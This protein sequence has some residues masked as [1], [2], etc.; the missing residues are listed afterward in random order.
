VSDF[1]RGYRQ[2]VADAAALLRHID[3]LEKVPG[4]AA[5][6]PEQNPLWEAAGLLQRELGPRDRQIGSTV[7]HVHL[8]GHEIAKSVATAVADA[9]A[10]S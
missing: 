6:L 5:L 8:D 3:T 7:V 10:R 4:A 2:A 1:E 9:T